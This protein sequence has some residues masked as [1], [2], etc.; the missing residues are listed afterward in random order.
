MNLDNKN[1]DKIVVWNFQNKILYCLHYNIT[2]NIKIILI[3]Q[4]QKSKTYC[5]LTIIRLKIKPKMNISKK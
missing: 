2:K 3:L 4:C 5:L 1:N